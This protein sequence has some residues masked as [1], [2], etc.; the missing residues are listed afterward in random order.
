[1]LVHELVHFLL[2]LTVGVVIFRF[3]RKW[4]VFGVSFVAG[5][6][7]DADHLFDYFLYKK[8]LVIQFPEFLQGKFFELTNKVY[9]PFHAFEYALLAI[10][11]GLF[12]LRTPGEI[13]VKRR[14]LAFLA[15]AFG[16]SL[17]CHL[18]F[19]TLAYKPKWPTYFISYRIFNHFD[20]N[21]LGFE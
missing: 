1:M 4:Q 20:H 6:F 13:W 8:N 2:S 17:F 5:F 3:Y 12:L 18:V 9:L 21:E 19:D 15:L 11:L 16:I 14:G 10:I 7:V